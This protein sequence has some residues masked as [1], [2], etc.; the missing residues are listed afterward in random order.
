MLDLITI[1]SVLLLT[2]TYIAGS[3]VRTECEH[4]CFF[5]LYSKLDFHF[6]F[7]NLKQKC[8][9]DWSTT[10]VLSTDINVV[11]MLHFMQSSLPHGSC[12]P[13]CIQ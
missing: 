6:H 11:P 7:S 12:S 1:Q 5:K 3:K 2:F 8:S 10:F 4:D 9:C 13:S